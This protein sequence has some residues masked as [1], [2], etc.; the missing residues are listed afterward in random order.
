MHQSNFWQCACNRTTKRTPRRHQSNTASCS[1]ASALNWVLWVQNT[2]AGGWWLVNRAN[3]ID[4]QAA[5]TEL[6]P[7]THPHSSLFLSHTLSSLFPSHTHSSLFPSHTHSPL[8]PSHTHSS[9][10]PSHSHS[11]LLH[12]LTPPHPLTYLCTV[13]LLF[14]N[15]KR[16]PSHIPPPPQ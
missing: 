5:C 3:M 12:T 6:L 8:F 2:W 7:F 13:P 16:F 10:F 11:F 4:W 15:W 14:T 1:L 9:L